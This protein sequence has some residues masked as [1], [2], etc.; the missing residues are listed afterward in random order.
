M[1]DQK[2]R[3]ERPYPGPKLRPRPVGPGRFGGSRRK[4]QRWSAP[5][6]AVNDRPRAVNR[7][8]SL[9]RG[10]SWRDRPPVP[11]CGAA[12]A[13]RR[14]RKRWG[15]GR[16][17]WRHGAVVVPSTDR[18]TPPPDPMHASWRH[19]A[20]GVASTLPRLVRRRRGVGGVARETRGVR[21]PG[22]GQRGNTQR[23]GAARRAR[24]WKPQR[25]VAKGR[26][27]ER[28]RVLSAAGRSP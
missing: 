23:C 19:G 18:P 4:Q 6:R 20:L 15:A 26:G 17:S 25:E 2:G 27:D 16:V 12:G 28:R 8:N 9:D 24:R 21:G 7:V 10:R 11:L 5:T 13:R 14:H 1:E 3:G 22:W